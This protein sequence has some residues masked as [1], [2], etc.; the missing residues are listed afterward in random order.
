MNL[1]QVNEWLTLVA[2][3]GVVVGIVFVG[4]QI[5]LTTDAVRSSG[6]A[7]R[8]TLTGPCSTKS[9]AATP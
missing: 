7:L 4:Y 6:P 1:E 5:R 8:R 3:I 2:N 9:N